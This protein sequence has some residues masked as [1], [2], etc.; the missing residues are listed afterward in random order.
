VGNKQR[1]RRIVAAAGFVLALLL[2]SHCLELDLSIGTG[3]FTFGDAGAWIHIGPV[4]PC[5]PAVQGSR[6]LGVECDGGQQA[7]LCVAGTAAEDAGEPPL[8]AAC[9]GPF[10]LPAPHAEA[11]YV[12]YCCAADSGGGD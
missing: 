7:Y 3:W 2:L 4:P 11:G 5:I 6:S 8:P 1:A 12:G 10:A 9:G